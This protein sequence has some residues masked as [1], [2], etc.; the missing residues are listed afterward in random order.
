VWWRLFVVVEVGANHSF[1]RIRRGYLDPLKLSDSRFKRWEDTVLANF[2]R[3]EGW[4]TGQAATGSDAWNNQGSSGFSMFQPSGG[5]GSGGNSSSGGGGALAAPG[6]AS[7]PPEA[8]KPV[9]FPK[10]GG[11]TL[12][13]TT[14]TRRPP[15]AEARAAMLE[16]AARRAAAEN[17]V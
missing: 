12:G 11:R 3:R 14:P 8:A 16:A 4:V 17:N 5:G 9:G 6:P 13:G 1:S 15:T 7:A 2:T 10:G